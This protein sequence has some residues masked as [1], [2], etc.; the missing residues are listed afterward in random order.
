MMMDPLAAFTCHRRQPPFVAEY[1]EFTYRAVV[2]PARPKTPW[3]ASRMSGLAHLHAAVATAFSD[4]GTQFAA[5]YLCGGYSNNVGILP[6]I[7]AH[8]GVCVRCE[9]VAAGPCVYRC[10][11]GSGELIYIGSAV[12][13][14]NRLQYHKS[15]SAWWPEVAD[16]KTVYY[17]TI[18]EA[19][20]VERLAIIAEKPLRNGPFGRPAKK[21]A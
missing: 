11:G 4:G 12:A 16:V 9:D 10:Y 5:R 6:N 7:D 18:F 21:S 15:Q 13:R 2:Y 17:P 3:V 14:R 8:G 20:A 1:P 19:R